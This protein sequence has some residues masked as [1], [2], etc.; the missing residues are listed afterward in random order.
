MEIPEEKLLSDLRNPDCS[1]IDYLD[2]YSN[3]FVE[4][5]IELFWRNI[6][7]N[8]GLSKSHIINESDSGYCYFYEVINGKKMPTRDKVIRLALAMNMT[9]N[10][11]QEALKVSGHSFLYPKNRRDSILIYAIE[12]G[13]DVIQCNLLLDKYNEEPLK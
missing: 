5:G 10:E 8:K 1:L 11:C 4:G 12:K 7:N 6:I 13:L 2:E 9:F 3:I